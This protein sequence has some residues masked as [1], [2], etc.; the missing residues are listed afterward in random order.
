MTLG[1]RGWRR[2][3]R[4]GGRAR[5]G[6]R[7]RRRRPCRDRRALF[8]ACPHERFRRAGGRGNPIAGGKLLEDF[9]VEDDL[10]VFAAE[11]AESRLQTVS[12][13]PK[14]AGNAR[15][16][17]SKCA[18]SPEIPTRCARFSRS[19]PRPWAIFLASDNLAHCGRGGRR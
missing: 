1:T 14:L 15:A 11:L 18:W 9:L 3:R 16:T 5:R 8:R 6:G 4:R 19:A 13:G 7:R 2:S 12:D 10:L 17:G